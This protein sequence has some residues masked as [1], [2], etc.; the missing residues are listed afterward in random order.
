M[1]VVCLT[2]ELAEAPDA[3]AP[4]RPGWSSLLLKVPR[5]GPWGGEDAGAFHVILA[6]PPGLGSRATHEA[7]VGGIVAVMGMLTVD[8]DYSATTRQIHYAVIAESIERVRS[9]D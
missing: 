7:D 5:R 2:G 4:V 3:R 6:L 1:N 9:I 8:V